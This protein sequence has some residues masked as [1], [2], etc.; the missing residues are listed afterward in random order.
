MSNKAPGGRDPLGVFSLSFFSS[1]WKVNRR[2]VVL[3]M[4]FL[5]PIAVVL[6]RFGRGSFVTKEGNK[7]H[8]RFPTTA[9][10]NDKEIFGVCRYRLPSSWKVVVQDLLLLKKRK[11]TDSGQKPSRMTLLNND[12]TNSPSSRS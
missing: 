1:S 8:N 2:G 12:T 10:G 9:L 3:D 6:E 4:L 7:G 11:T 5:L